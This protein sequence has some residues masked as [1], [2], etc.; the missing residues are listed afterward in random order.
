MTNLKAFAVRLEAAQDDRDTEIPEAHR[1]AVGCPLDQPEVQQPIA[2]WM[3]HFTWAGR[4]MMPGHLHAIAGATIT[5]SLAVRSG[6]EMARLY[7][8]SQPTVSRI[9]AAH[10]LKEEIGDF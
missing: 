10:R 1:H 5:R 8:I 9:V 4:P 7:N 2:H 6:A 3:F